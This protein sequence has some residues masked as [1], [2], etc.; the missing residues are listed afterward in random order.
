MIYGEPSTVICELHHELFQNNMGSVP[1]GP[2][3]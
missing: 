2:A 1:K 3:A